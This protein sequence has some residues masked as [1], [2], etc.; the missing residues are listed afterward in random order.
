MLRGATPSADEIAG[1]AVLRIVVS[2]DSIK[3][4]TATSQGS[5]RFE[6]SEGLAEDGGATK[7]SSGFMEEGF[8]LTSDAWSTCIV[9]AI[10]SW[11]KTLAEEVDY[12]QKY[13]HFRD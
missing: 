12:S 1:T 8:Q 9:A 10:V 11:P 3:K 2:S 4:A 13:I 6:A 5:R 7:E